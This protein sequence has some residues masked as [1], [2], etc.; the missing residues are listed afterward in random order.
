MNT[1]PHI[2]PQN[3]EAEKSVLGSILLDFDGKAIPAIKGILREQDFYVE[4]HR[5][6]YTAM[7]DLF[8]QH[9]PVDLVT[10]TSLLA[11]RNQL[12]SIGGA[13]AI[14][15][16]TEAVP[17]ATRVAEY[18]EIVAKK[19]AFRR[20]LKLGVEIQ[21]AAY[22]DDA[23]MQDIL[24]RINASVSEIVGERDAKRIFTSAQMEEAFYEQY[25]ERKENPN[26][27]EDGIST[28]LPSLDLMVQ[29]FHPGELIVVAGRA[30]MGKTALGVSMAE[31]MTRMGKRVLFFT[32]EMSAISLFSRIVASITGIDARTLRTG[33]T[34]DAQH[35]TLMNT[36]EVLHGR[37]FTFA[38]S[39][40]Y[41]VEDIAASA[42]KEQMNGGLDAIFVDYVGLIEGNNPKNRVQEVDDI[43][44]GLVRLAKELN[45][46][47]VLLAQINRMVEGRSNKQPLLSDLRESGAIEQNADKVLLLY[48][49]GYYD[50]NADQREY[51]VD[52]AKHRNGPT[53]DV[54]IFFDRE[55]MRFS[56]PLGAVYHRPSIGLTHDDQ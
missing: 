53:G 54:Q 20:L 35:E 18:A 9:K 55:L 37:T 29:G 3:I 26:A 31:H 7:L 33:R 56:D 15:E 34:N 5:T 30:S 25:A 49:P 46:P 41:H 10:L 17:T 52:V 32:F 1:T 47:I 13:A 16:L 27:H 23:D 22:R 40:G 28:G 24:R 21:D 43:T 42:M 14:A 2:P 11:D 48:R 4:A 36:L 19:A 39:Y 12:A 50:K 45:V 8:R 44:R 38:E 51:H 6:I